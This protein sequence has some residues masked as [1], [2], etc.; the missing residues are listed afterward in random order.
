MERDVREQAYWLLLAFVSG[1]PKRVVNEI[2]QLWCCQLGRTLQA[3]FAATPR[4]WCAVYPLS[5]K[6]LEK[7]ARAK[8]KFDDQVALVG[9]LNH[10]SMHVLTLLDDDYPRLLKVVLAPHQQ[11]PVLCYAGDLQIL[12]LISIAIIGSRKAGEASLAFTREVARYLA[13]QGANVISGNARGVDR[14]A[15]EGAA[16]TEGC[17]TVVLP[18]GIRKLSKVQMQ[19]LSPKIAA[20]N[21]LLLSQFHP[22]AAWLVS[23]AMERNKVVTGL[24]QAVIVAESGVKGGTWEGA[25]EALRRQ[26]PVYVCQMEPASAFPGNQAL[27]EPGGRPL[28]W[29]TETIEDDLSP[30]MQESEFLYKANGCRL[31]LSNQLLDLLKE[32]KERMAH[33]YA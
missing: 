28:F 18:H 16:S 24:A 21:V 6:M 27:L 11:P 8:T 1:L 23:R 3:F 15:Y 9:Q 10:D 32:Q 19:E 22:D 31:S 17:T 2:I 14:A 20:G 13:E 33:D 25:N 26:Q 30:L 12:E 29:S 7:L 4:E 5:R